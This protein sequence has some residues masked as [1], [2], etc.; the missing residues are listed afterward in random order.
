MPLYMD[1]HNLPGAVAADV[2]SAHELDM[3]AQRKYNVK[4]LTYWFDG[5]AERT[6]CLIDAPNKQA[7]ETVHREAHG[8]VPAEIMEVNQGIVEEFLGK[9]G[10]T[11]A[12]ETNFKPEHPPEESAFRIILFTDMVGSTS[13]TQRLGDAAAMDL[14][15]AHDKIIRTALEEHRGSEVKHTGDGIMASFL[16]AS[17]AVECSIS[18]QRGFHVQAEEQPDHA[19]QIRI[20]LTAGE[21]V[22]EHNDLFG[23]AVQLAARIC[24]CADA[25]AILVANVIRELC[26][27]K[28]FLFA[29]TGEQT[30]R[31]FDDAVRLYEVRWQEDASAPSE[32]AT[33]T[34][35]SSPPETKSFASGRYVVV[36]LLGQGAQKSAYLVDDTTLGRQSA[37]SILNPA[38]L[39]RRDK[40]RIKQ[41]AQTMAQF[42]S[43]PNIVTVY[44]YGEEDGA[45]FIVC[46]Y[47]SGGELREE[48]D[49]A[50]G[51]LS[52]KR[53]LTVAIDIC[54]ALSF[55]HRRNIV[56]RDLKPANVWLTEERT[57]KLGDFGIALS[58]GRTR[59]TMPGSVT[60]TATYMAPEQASGGDVDARSDLYAFGALLYELVTGRPPF[61]GDDPNA[62]IYQHINTKPESPAKHNAS[63]PPGLERLIMRLLAKTK[64]E[65]PRSA[66]DVLTELERAVVDLA[67]GPAN[68]NPTRSIETESP[69]A[70]ATG[71]AETN[72]LE[73]RRTY[74]Q[75]VHAALRAHDG[76]E[77]NHSGDDI[78]ASFATASSALECAITIQRSVAAHKEDHPDAPLAVDIGLNAGEPVAEEQ[79]LQNTSVDMATRICEQE[80]P[81]QILVSNVIKD[82]AADKG[83]PFTDAGEQ[84][85]RGFEDAVR[86]YEV[87]WQQ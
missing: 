45:P 20:G 54:R 19:V 55:A 52:P 28:G 26:I 71:L 42:G 10:E 8:L 66:E 14:L 84:T 7:V 25:S 43:Q 85:R 21:P 32:D 31:G 6:F 47:V 40:E 46:E 77:T 81:S 51:P 22:M 60:G 68:V 35:I 69:T 63:V 70:G 62:I 17:S 59:L 37:L 49:A 86:L 5:E 24:D 64:T 61:V 73:I 41:E 33:Q 3:A 12:S 78:K 23:A 36:K 27:G 29:D 74:A 56:H 76:T 67:R 38:L 44:D 50:A 72:A 48:L 1:R 80:E 58:L 18:I 15:R 82:L 87:R 39:D 53:A 34:R 9:V 75:I 83:F 57:A 11:A 4:F 2:A 65:R 30:L 79:G 16:Q 13:M